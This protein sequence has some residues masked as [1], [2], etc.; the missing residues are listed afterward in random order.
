MSRCQKVH[1]ANAIED[2]EKDFIKEN[3]DICKLLTEVLGKINQKNSNKIELAA[4]IAEEKDRLEDVFKMQIFLFSELIN[5]KLG[6]KT[7]A[8]ELKSSFSLYSTEELAR[9]IEEILETKE[10]IEMNVNLNICLES[11]LY[12]LT[13][14][15]ISEL[16]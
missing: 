13:K 9:C 2:K 3:R 10:M 6:Y 16:S 15:K 4:R 1:F 12:K 8:N 11:L 14:E 7:S 5:D